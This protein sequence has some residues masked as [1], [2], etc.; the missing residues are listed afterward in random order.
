MRPTILAHRGFTLIELLAAVAIVGILAGILIPVA[1][2]VRKQ[3]QIVQNASTIRSLGLAILAYTNDHKGEFPRSLHSAG[4]H[5]QP[6]WSASI[7]PYLGIPQKAIEDNWEAV[8]NE[9]YRSPVTEETSPT[10]FSY[11]LNVHFELSKDEDYI[12]NPKTWR[13]ISQVPSPSR[14]VLLA[15]VRPVPFGDHLMCHMWSGLNGAKNAVLH[16]A[17]SGKSHYFF[18]DGSVA[19]LPIEETFNPADQRNL[20]N[21]S[22][23]GRL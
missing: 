14:T 6:G 9:Y 16:D 13:R 17:F 4:T 21:P 23:A 18:V 11:G 2:V 8:F 12:G 19:L 22:L 3:A 15:Q 5:R 7:A 10:I 1:Q 20:W